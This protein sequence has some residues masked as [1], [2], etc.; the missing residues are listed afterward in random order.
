MLSHAKLH[1]PILALTAALT[2]AA[3]CER[4]QPPAAK[5]AAVSPAPASAADRYPATLAEGIRFSQPGYPAFLA[6]VSGL[7]HHEP[8]G[9]WSDGSPVVFQFAQPLPTRFTLVLTAHA[10]GPNIGVPIPVKAGAT[11]QTLTLTAEDQT[12]RLDFTLATPTDRLEFHIPQP[13]SPADL[14]QG[15]DPR[16]LGI[17][18]VQ[19]QLETAEAPA[20]SA[21]PAVEP[22]YAAT[23]TATTDRLE[24]EQGSF[25]R[26][27]LTLTNRGRLTWT[28]EPPHPVN[29]SYHLLDGQGKMITHDNPRTSFPQPV[30]PGQTATLTLKLG[31]DRIPGPGDYRMEFDL[32]QEGQTWFAAK[33][34]PTLTLPV[35]VTPPTQVLLD[36]AQL[37]QPQTSALQVGDLPE[38]GALWRLIQNTLAYTHQEF[39]IGERRYQG[40]SAGGGYPQLWARDSATALHGSRWFYPQ[41]ALRDWIEL[42]LTHQ[43]PDGS[44]P[45]WVNARNQTDKNT[46]ETDQE[47]SLVIGAGH[48]QR[49]AGDAAWLTTQFNGE[50]LLSRLHRALD[51][52]WQH[53]RDPASGLLTGAHTIDWGDIEL[54]ECTQ[55]AIYAGP[56]SLW[57]IDLY[58]QAMLALAARPLADLHEAAGDAQAAQT[59]R[60]RADTLV[61]QTRT[62]LWQPERGY[63]RMHRHL[64]SHDHPFDEDAL[65]PMGGNAV[66]IQA[67]IADPGM[68]ER[69]FAVARQ[70]QAE[71]AVSTISGVLL[72]PYPD[73]VY[74]HPAVNKAWHYQNGGQWDWFGAR[75]ILAMYE[76]GYSDAA[77]AALRQIAQKNVAYHS[78]NEWDDRSGHPQGSPWY[79]GSAGVLSRALVEGTFGIDSQHQTLTLRPRLKGVSGRIAL[80]EPATGRRIAYDYRADPD[81][82]RL[83]LWTDHPALA[84]VALTLPNAWPST[85]V[86]MVNGEPVTYQ[87]GQIGE[88]RWLRIALPPRTEPTVIEILTPRPHE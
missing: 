33:G 59:W 4:P 69:I 63:F 85:S 30:A 25:I 45:D 38:F 5:S 35:T 67:G 43:N 12:Q 49:L 47:T 77:T 39:A 68:A 60:Q 86:V 51:Y 72:P 55:D 64:S 24:I 15:E 73:N 62:Q 83:T 46:V 61:A 13:T 58:D 80:R 6:T 41:P 9:R 18:F 23:I 3:C 8:W 50:P 26:S 14:Q 31:A 74:C 76:A 54:G 82:L 65:F 32:V 48:Y 17:G 29:L 19:L 79:S 1:F 36:E 28:S 34:S 40:F 66:A 56:G 42:L 2:V 20:A 11:E 52:V 78:I 57:T 75:L 88:D 10:F 87:A 37:A 44:I 22:D 7:S 16:K 71:Y 84:T 70:R 21:T 53:R 81:Q 27:T